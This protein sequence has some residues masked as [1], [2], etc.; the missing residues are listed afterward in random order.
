VI[1]ALKYTDEGM[2]PEKEQILIVISSVMTWS[3]TP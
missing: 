3:M 1:K 2:K